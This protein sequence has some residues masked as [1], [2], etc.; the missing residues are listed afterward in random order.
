M[1]NLLKRLQSEEKQTPLN[2]YQPEVTVDNNNPHIV[3]VVFDM[4]KVAEITVE[5][6]GERTMQNGQ[7][8]RY[9][10]NPAIMLSLI[11]PDIAIE[12]IADDGTLHLIACKFQ[13]GQG[14]NGAY[15]TLSPVEDL[16]VV[17]P[18]TAT[19]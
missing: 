5:R 15:A 4:K 8:R 19:A 10:K 9:T 17:K 12:Q 1:A 16:G 6:D 14:G 18:A 3:S 11:V 2:V 13:L 7:T